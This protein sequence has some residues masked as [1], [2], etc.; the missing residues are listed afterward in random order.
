V[1]SS[2]AVRRAVSLLRGIQPDASDPQY[3]VTADGQRFL[4]LVPVEEEPN[5]L[6]LLLNWLGQPAGAMT[7]C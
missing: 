7:L 4:G 5:T 2:W 6:T 3:A 1:P